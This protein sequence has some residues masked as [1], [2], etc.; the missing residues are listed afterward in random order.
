MLDHWISM[1]FLIQ[2]A[3]YSI[4]PHGLACSKRSDSGE[5]CGVEHYLNAWN[6]LPMD[7]LS[8]YGIPWNPMGTSG[9]PMAFHGWTL[10]Y[11]MEFH[12][13][14]SILHGTPWNSMDTPWDS[15][16]L[17]GY[18][19]ELRPWDSMEFHGSSME[20]HGFPLNSMDFHRIPWRY[21]TQEVKLLLK[22]NNVTSR[23]NYLLYIQW[24]TSIKW[25]LAI[26][27]GV[28]A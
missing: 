22:V 26:T 15:M 3:W 23:Q 13:P 19:M 20:F 11:S 2:T 6:R 17:H 8:F 18:S 25:P 4:E 14:P 28:V 10:R 5:R 16:E 12:W 24:P 7:T 21:F 1:D 9:N 27:P